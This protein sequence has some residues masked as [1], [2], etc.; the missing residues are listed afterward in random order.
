MSRI[1][2]TLTLNHANKIAERVNELRKAAQS[3]CGVN[4][5]Q[6][7]YST[8][9]RSQCEALQERANEAMAAFEKYTLLNQI[10]GEI[11]AS[12]GEANEKAGVSRI[13]AQIDA[14]RQERS[15]A[16][17]FLAQA[18]SQATALRISDLEGA[19]VGDSGE[20][21]TAV[22]TAYISKIEARATAVDRAIFQ[23]Q[24]KLVEANARR[25]TITLPS[26]IA[27][28]LGLEGPELVD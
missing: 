28:E 2:T 7:F 23:L 10:R 19:Q 22:D 20:N 11:R 17:S 1:K 3:A 16:A 25:L 9:S 26:D 5:G 27:Q 21:I 15:V 6:C 12:I 4:L 13:L 18:K 14:L 24:D 8:P